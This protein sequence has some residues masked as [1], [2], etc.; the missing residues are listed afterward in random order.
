MK[1]F[2][3]RKPSLA[4]RRAMEE[5]AHFLRASQKEEITKKAKEAFAKTTG[6]KNVWLTES[7][8]AALQLALTAVKGRILLPDQ[9]IWKGTSKLCKAMGIQT[10]NLPTDYG[11]V[12]TEGLETAIKKHRPAAF[13]IT[14]FAG[15]IAEQDVPAISR[16]CKEHE[17]L[18]IEDCSSSIGDKGLAKGRFSDIIAGSTKTPKLLNLKTGGFITTDIDDALKRIE[19]NWKYFSDPVFCAGVIEELKTSQ[20]TIDKLSRAAENLRKL[21]ESPVHPGKRGLCVGVFLKEPAKTSRNAR[22]SGL[23]TESGRSIFTRCPRSDRFLE[24]GLVVEL[25]KIGFE[26]LSLKNLEEI[27]QALEVKTEPVL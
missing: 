15:Y 19:K 6:H 10:M 8:E 14:S 9:G 12:N 27:A 3:D 26:S 20:K 22:R 4:A 7:G 18:L 1:P 2:K 23:V 16:I 17:V 24:K 21:L 11:V 5:A 13:L 25:K